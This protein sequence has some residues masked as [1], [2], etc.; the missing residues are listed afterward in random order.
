MSSQIPLN[1]GLDSHPIILQGGM[2][3]KVF[4]VSEFRCLDLMEEVGSIVVESEGKEGDAD[5]V[6][7]E[8]EKLGTSSF[9]SLFS[10]CHISKLGKQT[11]SFNC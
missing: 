4:L 1:W 11:R 7:K 2:A 10:K 9:L 3:G 5:L 6:T 8:K